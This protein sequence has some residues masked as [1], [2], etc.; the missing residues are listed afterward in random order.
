MQVIDA[1]FFFKN[2]II[3]I[4]IVLG[5]FLLAFGAEVIDD[6]SIFVGFK[7]LFSWSLMLLMFPAFIF[8]I[9]LL[10]AFIKFFSKNIKNYNKIAVSQ[11]R[12]DLLNLGFVEIIAENN[13][14]ITGIEIPHFVLM[15]IYETLPLQIESNQ[16]DEIIEICITL[17]LEIDKD[18]TSYQQSFSKQYHSQNIKISQE[19]IFKIINIAD[20]VEDK[21][22]WAAIHELQNIVNEEE[23]KEQKLVNYTLINV[24]YGLIY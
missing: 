22:I 3:A 20:A 1:K 12:K 15:G 17:N 16:Y 11:W 6:H 9:I 23:Y 10:F 21:N 13:D 18:F 7:I 14:T 19:K 24:N 4:S 8:L 5:I 2:N